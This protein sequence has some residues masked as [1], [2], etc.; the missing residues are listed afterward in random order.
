MNDHLL[1]TQAKP[2]LYFRRKI[3]FK[4]DRETFISPKSFISA[5]HKYDPVKLEPPIELKSV[6]HRVDKGTK[7]EVF[8][9]FAAA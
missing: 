6:V 1:S 5:H 8:S 2:A 7:D 4:D 9:F 3:P